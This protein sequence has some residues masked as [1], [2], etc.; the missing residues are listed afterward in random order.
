[1]CWARDP[2]SPASVSVSVVFF[3][4]CIQHHLDVCIANYAS[5]LAFELLRGPAPEFRDFVRIKFKNGTDSD[6]QT[7]RVFGH[8]EDSLPVT[9]FIYR[10]EVRV[11]MTMWST[12]SPL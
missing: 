2:T 4:E 10:L 6:F 9:E 8:A 12:C 11:P 1:V 7:I 5:A 3:Q